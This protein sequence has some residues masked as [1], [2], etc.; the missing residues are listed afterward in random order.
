[1]IFF[2]GLN[3]DFIS[4]FVATLIS[5]CERGGGRIRS[6]DRTGLDA[7]TSRQDNKESGKAPRRNATE[8]FDVPEPPG[9]A[10]ERSRPSFRDCHN[11]AAAAYRLRPRCLAGTIENNVWQLPRY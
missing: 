7:G 9:T 8:H 2:L 1:L 11:P 5:R 10:R 3:F 6:R 4:S